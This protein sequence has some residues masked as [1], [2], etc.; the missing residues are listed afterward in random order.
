MIPE[1]VWVLAPGLMDEL[2]IK[3]EGEDEATTLSE[4]LGPVDV[5]DFLRLENA[6]RTYISSLA[7]GENPNVAELADALQDYLT[8][9]VG[10]HAGADGSVPVAI[11][12][13][14]SQGSQILQF[15]VM[16][17]FQKDLLA[18][19]GFAL[20]AK[21]GETSLFTLPII[22]ELE[23]GFGINLSRVHSGGGVQAE[24]LFFQLKKFDLKLGVSIQD[25]N[26]GFDLG[27]VELDVREVA[28]DFLLGATIGVKDGVVTKNTISLDTF[29]ENDLD[30][31]FEVTTVGIENGELRLRAKSAELVLG[32]FSSK[33]IDIENTLET[34][35]MD[36]YALHGT[37]GIKS[38]SF[39]LNADM[40][41]LRLSNLLEAKIP[42][43][44]LNYDPSA[45]T[46]QELIAV[47]KQPIVNIIPLDNKELSIKPVSTMVAGQEVLR[48]LSIRDNGLFHRCVTPC[49]HG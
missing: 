1:N 24:D 12:V 3:L 42:G 49:V 47:K 16:Y 36:E 7:E 26:F 38:K 14:Y 39:E 40:W 20:P 35:D 19:I 23:F 8:S 25:L 32:P 28:V 46:G 30:A 45:P 21:D 33:V 31:L 18:S 48:V 17:L 27:S 11:T 13:G 41:I 44:S 15:D 22:F 34:G 9:L 6:F 29:A 10:S 43:F 4:V 5:G 2:P 37:Y